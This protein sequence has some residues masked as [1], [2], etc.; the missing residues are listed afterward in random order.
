MIKNFLSETMQSRTS[1]I[2]WKKN[3]HIIL[4]FYIQ[5]KLAFKGEG[6][7]KIFLYKSQ[8]NL[9]PVDPQY[10]KCQRKL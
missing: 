7:V 2:W 9:L 3:L 8:E 5:W 6:E 1:L 10:K 4:E